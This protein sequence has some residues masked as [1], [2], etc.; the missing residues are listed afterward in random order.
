MK[1]ILL[2]LFLTVFSQNVFSQN[3]INVSVAVMNFQN[4]TGE[5]KL[6]YMR[7]L[8]PQ[9][10]TTELV[11]NK[12]INV[13]ERERLEKILAEH[14]LSLLGLLDKEDIDKLG[15]ILN[16][17]Y[18]IFGAV[19]FSSGTLRIDSHIVNVSTAKIEEA[20]KVYGENERNIEDACAI[21]A[22]KISSAILGEKEEKEE[23][24]IGEGKLEFIPILNNPYLVTGENQKVY[25]MIKL[26][27][28]RKILTSKRMPLNI[29]FVI[30]RSGSMGS[31]NKLEYVKQACSFAID[32]LSSEDIISIVTYDDVSNVNY[33][34][35]FVK[36]KTIIKEIIKNLTPGGSTN[37][38]AGMVS[39]YKEVFKN[40]S[41]DKLN[42]VIL[43]SDGLAN[44]GE[45]RAEVLQKI[46]K[47]N[48]SEGVSLTTMGVGVDYNENLMLNLAEYGS[49]NYYFIDTPEKA[50]EIFAS[51]FRGL[52]NVIA[53]KIKLKISPLN[54]AEVSK[55]FG[56]KFTKDG[57]DVYIEIFS[58]FE[59]E[60][61]RILV[62]ITP[63][64]KVSEE[65]LLL[66]KVTL[67]YEDV[68]NIR[69]QDTQDIKISYIKDKEIYNKSFNKEV[70][71]EIEIAKST[72]AMEKAAFLM[73]E[74]KYEEASLILRKQAKESIKNSLLL[75]S[76]RLNANASIL[77]QNC[78][79][80]D[81]KANENKKEELKSMISPKFEDKLSKNIAAVPKSVQQQAYANVKGKA[82]GKGITQVK[83]E[84]YENYNKTGV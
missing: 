78:A 48:L 73:N 7:I 59:K 21:L 29:S 22:A 31:E 34:A 83:Q 18:L 17:D 52:L 30:D 47:D 71:E 9:I 43:L 16:V 84:E 53:R 23:V 12:K 26:L 11:K 69:K 37:L 50:G 81:L 72:E 70:C 56:Y 6:D 10:L 44:V 24:K 57:K 79:Q 65:K 54:G 66:A 80:V 19:S 58:M 55:V 32:H 42:R 28:G 77:L 5:K 25:L 62:E 27:A 33:K 68:K 64:A 60:E 63:P 4:L 45:T 74:G 1:K 8:I 38:H 75:R 2:F 35:D 20:F 49:G 51:E 67:E 15:K 3:R 14:K 82:V 76:E 40:L 61:R 13:V 41:K 46:A 36:D 39:G